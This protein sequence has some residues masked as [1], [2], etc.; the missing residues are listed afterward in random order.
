MNPAAIFVPVEIKRAD[1]TIAIIHIRLTQLE[2]PDTIIARA[3]MV[4]S[5][6]I[7]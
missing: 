7:I 3:E 6:R 5:Q 1:V 4:S 2:K